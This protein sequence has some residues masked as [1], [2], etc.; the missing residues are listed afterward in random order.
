MDK[1]AIISLI[2][3]LQ[4]CNDIVPVTRGQVMTMQPA[5]S[6]LE[7]I[8]QGLVMVSIEPV[9]DEAARS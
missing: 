4:R 2:H 1:V 8:A 5:I 7:A 3:Y 6:Q 9:A